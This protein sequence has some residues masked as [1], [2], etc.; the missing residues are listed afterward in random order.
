MPAC[1]VRFVESNNEFN[2]IVIC[3]Q[4]HEYKCAAG[5]VNVNLFF[6]KQKA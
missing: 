4:A 3:L 1:S 6:L 2:K 5:S